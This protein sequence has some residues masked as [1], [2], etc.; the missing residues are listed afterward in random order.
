MNKKITILMPNYNRDSYIAQAI[1]SVLM[2]QTN[3]AYEL[4]IID[5]G[6]TDNSL[7][8]ITD[9]KDKF[10]DKITLIANEKNQGCLSASLKG[11]E[12][13]KTEYF[14]VLDSDDY[15]LD[16]KKLQN[17]V[18]FLDNNVDYVMYVAN[19]YIEENGERTPYYYILK[20]KSFSFEDIDKIIWGHT[21][22]VI[23]RNVI[24]KDNVS[25]YLFEQIGTDK[26]KS[27]EGDTFRNILHLKKGKAYYT[28]KF[29]SVY[30]VTGKGIWT[31]YN[32]FQQNTL[33][34]GFFLDIFEYMEQISP[35]YFIRAAFNF[36]N[37]NLDL[38]N[39]VVTTK[40]PAKDILNFYKK[41]AR[42]LDYKDKLI[43]HEDNLYFKFLIYAPSKIDLKNQAFLT[44]MARYLTDKLEFI[45][46]YVD[47]KNSSA[48]DDLKDSKVKFIEYHDDINLLN[49]FRQINIIAP[50]VFA[51]DLN[52]LQE[53]KII[54]WS[55]SKDDYDR[56]KE[57]TSL[58]D[59]NAKKALELFVNNICFTNWQT[60][61]S[62]RT[63]SGLDLKET[64]VPLFY[65]HKNEHKVI[66]TPQ[67]AFDDLISLGWLDDN[68]SQNRDNLVSF[69]NNFYELKTNLKKN[70][71]IIDSK[72]NPE[73]LNKYRDKINFIFINSSNDEF[74]NIINHNID[75]IFTDNTSSVMKAIDFNLPVLLSLVSAELTES[76]DKY[77]WLFDAKGYVLELTEE[78]IE[79]CDNSIVTLED[80]ITIIYSHDMKQELQLRC[81][82]HMNSKHHI[83]ETITKLLNFT[84]KTD[85]SA[86]TLIKMQERALMQVIRVNKRTIKSIIKG[87]ARRLIR[88]ANYIRGYGV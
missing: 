27:F 46:Y 62:L 60:W 84:F 4:L 44:E 11:Y 70:L 21:S 36:C 34:M 75:L 87:V 51:S 83:E 71:H 63:K 8:I 79:L 74:K 41:A 88:F 9:Y 12:Y 22:G 17:A 56:F 73:S 25:P 15:W 35:K 57:D 52:N 23:F 85:S 3:F 43:E 65:D 48:K 6:S 78:Q 82:H 54:L 7:A 49:Q 69:I 61:V 76:Y 14:C 66:S 39:N 31:S 24:F 5:D 26:E 80:I 32:K 77:L 59:E 53:T 42:C 33:N 40:I 81:H 10:P 47:Y 13:T 50:L 18:D 72:I 1:D 38:I 30:R 64:Y 2:Q 45:V 58:N 37:Q 86:M 20:S 55:T 29:E 16:S 68:N 28:P 19:T 67:I